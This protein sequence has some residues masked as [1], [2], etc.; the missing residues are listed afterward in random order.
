M[1]CLIQRVKSASVTSNGKTTGNIGP[2]ILVFVCATTHDNE[3]ITTK[4]AKKVANLRIFSDSDGKMNHSIADVQGEILVVSQFT[5]AADLSR[6]N[7]PG[8]SN[9]ARN[10]LAE[11]LY[12]YFIDELKDMGF[13]VETGIFGA[14]MEVSLV[15]DGPV[16]IWAEINQ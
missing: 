1:R 8:F 7:R 11:E 13:N 2:G 6:G 15:N 14:E 5:L 9:A 4:I 16:T 12:L 3:Q 10:P